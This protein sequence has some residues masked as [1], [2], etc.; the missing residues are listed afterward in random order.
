MISAEV[1]SVRRRHV[2]P[3]G[4][5][6]GRRAAASISICGGRRADVVARERVRGRRRRGRGAAGTRTSTTRRSRGCR[7]RTRH[8]SRGSGRA[9]SAPSSVAGSADIEPDGRRC[10]PGAMAVSHLE[11]GHLVD[12]RPSSLALE[13]AVGGSAPPGSPG[14]IRRR[15]S[16]GTRRRRSHCWRSRSSR[17]GIELRRQLV[18]RDAARPLVLPSSPRTRPVSRWS[19]GV[20][21]GSGRSRAAGSRCGRRRR[22]RR[23]SAPARRT[24]RALAGSPRSSSAVLSPRIASNV[25]SV[26]RDRRPAEAIERRVGQALV[27]VVEDRSV[28]GRADLDG[29]PARR[30]GHLDLSRAGSSNGRGSAVEQVA[31]RVGRVDLSR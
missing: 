9:R 3:P 10:A 27:D 16:T 23:S 1:S 20:R 22:H 31:R 21:R 5:L 19:S 18:E 11:L 17:L 26:S 6:R 25:R 7:R 2:V 29:R 24:A 30:A 13:Q 12:V 28:D 15:G 4:R 14:P 8:P